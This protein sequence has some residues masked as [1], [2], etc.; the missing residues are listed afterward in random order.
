MTRGMPPVEVFPVDDLITA[1]TAA[2]RNDP[3]VVLQ[4]GRSPGYKP[5]REWLGATCGV[6]AEN[7]LIGNSSLEIMDFIA[8]THLGPGKRVFVERPSYDRA[9]TML[10]RA[11][12]VVVGIPLLDDG[13][14]LDVFE[15][16]IKAG[17]PALFYTISDF[18]NPMGVTTSAEKRGRLAELAREHGFWIIEDAP[19]RKLRFWGEEAPTIYSLAPERV[20]HLSSFSKILAPG[21][22]LGYVVSTPEAISQLSA[23][24]VDTYIGPVLPTQG[25]VYEYCQAGLLEPNIAKLN[26][27]YAPRLTATLAALEEHFKGAT[28]T[29]PEGGFFVGVTLPEGTAMAQLLLRAE[30]AGIKLSDGRGFYPNPADGDRFLRIPFCSITPDDIRDGIARLAALLV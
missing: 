25:V 17:P 8:R 20:M 29:R 4:Y 24:A 18:Q 26:S 27:L 19:Y 2:L 23:F 14:D 30:Q 5:L 7:V 13:V 1:S 6:P 15:R 22:R 12:A 11:G 28:W 16:E 21:L 9:I 10:R 3:N